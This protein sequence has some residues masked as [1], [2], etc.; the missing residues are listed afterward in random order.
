MLHSSSSGLLF[1]VWCCLALSGVSGLGRAPVETVPGACS[2]PDVPAVIDIQESF[3]LFILTLSVTGNDGKDLGEIRDDNYFPKSRTWFSPHEEEVATE[4]WPFKGGVK[5]VEQVVIL[6]CKGVE[7]STI[8]V[9]ERKKEATIFRVK[10]PTNNLL[11]TTLQ[12]AKNPSKVILVD[13]S[14]GVQVATVEKFDPWLEPKRLR[15][16]FLEGSDLSHAADPR[17]LVMAA[18][19][20][21]TRQD[22]KK[23]DDNIEI[24]LLLI[25]LL[26]IGIVFC[27]NSIWG[28]VTGKQN[29]REEM[30]VPYGHQYRDYGS[31]PEDRYV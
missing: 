7:L 12:D 18:A 25:M 14:S 15:I 4:Y 3:Y 21:F 19:A 6:D 24:L 10:G 11:G 30:D 29:G 28:W 22:K 5:A 16:T 17:T 8:G 26:I 2:K 1:V 9:Q 23:R 13:E 31:V 20:E 27:I